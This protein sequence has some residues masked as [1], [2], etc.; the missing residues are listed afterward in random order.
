[1]GVYQMNTEYCN[2]NCYY[3]GNSWTFALGDPFMGKRLHEAE[4]RLQYRS[5]HDPEQAPRPKRGDIY[6]FVGTMV[7]AVVGGVLGY[8]GG[9]FLIMALATVGGAIVSA[10]VGSLIKKRIQK[11]EEAKYKF[12]AK[13]SNNH[14]TCKSVQM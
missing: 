1:M 3:G 2:G 12:W 5:E 8:L 13:M 11:R 9:S 6:I 7:G 14:F 10:A 4:M